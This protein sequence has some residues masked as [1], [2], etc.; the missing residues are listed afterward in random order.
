MR[1]NWGAETAPWG[2]EPEARAEGFASDS[3]ALLTLHPR[4]Q[5]RQGLGFPLGFPRLL[6]WLGWRVR[7]EGAPDPSRGFCASPGGWRGALGRRVLGG[8]EEEWLRIQTQEDVRSEVGSCSV[9]ASRDAP[10]L[11]QTHLCGA[12][13]SLYS[14]AFRCVAMAASG[15]VG[16]GPSVSRPTNSK[17]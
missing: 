5:E 10:K 4:E 3:R 9:L 12:A 6:L 2:T 17:L 1:V 13:W 7:V 14:L 8:L 11:G 15:T 16:F